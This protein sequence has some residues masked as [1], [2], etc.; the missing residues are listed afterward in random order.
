MS[1]W[2]ALLRSMEAPGTITPASGNSL[3]FDPL[4]ISATSLAVGGVWPAANRAIFL[5]FMVEAAVTAYMMAIEV[6]VQSG[7]CDIGI[8]DV[9]GVDRLVST[10]ST[11]VGAAGIQT[12]NITD[13]LLL[14]GVYW[15]ALCIDNITAAVTRSSSISAIWLQ[16]VGVQQQA[17]GAVTLPDPATLANPAAA[18]LPN[19]AVGLKAT[20]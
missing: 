20:I 8:Y 10:G 14:P 9:L 11:A 17:V 4:N 19:I 3:L 12:F 5:P 16:S 1:D 13:T 7:N 18:Y 6:T 15:A 2:P